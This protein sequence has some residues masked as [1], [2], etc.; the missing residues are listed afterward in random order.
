M[1]TSS[2]TVPRPGVMGEYGIMRFCSRSVGQSGEPWIDCR[3]RLPDRISVSAAA[4]TGIKPATRRPDSTGQTLPDPS[5][6]RIRPTQGRVRSR[7]RD[8]RC[9][10]THRS[11]PYRPAQNK[12]TIAPQQLRSG[13]L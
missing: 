13:S 12:Q 3:V 6:R 9:R 8:E 2:P 5:L 11:K 7:P 4:V 1:K 10:E